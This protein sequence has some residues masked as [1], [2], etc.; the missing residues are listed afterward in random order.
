M[1]IL[2]GTNSTKSRRARFK[3]LLEETMKSK[4]SLMMVESICD[5]PRII[6]ENVKKVKIH[7]PDFIGKDPE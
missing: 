1:A 7:N 4:Y 2:D 6:E 5:D 3:K